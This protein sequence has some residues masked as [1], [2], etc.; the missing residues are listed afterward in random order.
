LVESIKAAENAL[1]S[2]F[3]FYNSLTARVPSDEEI[4]TKSYINYII[5]LFTGSNFVEFELSRFL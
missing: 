3:A 5:Q 1:P 4:N 2:F